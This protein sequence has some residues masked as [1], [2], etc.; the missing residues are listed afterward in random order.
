MVSM[1]VSTPHVVSKDPDVLKEITRSGVSL[2]L[3]QRPVQTEIAREIASLEAPHLPDKRHK[4]TL[5]SLDG[6]VCEL[7][8]QRGLDPQAFRHL[9]ADM[10][11]LAYQL[12]Q[13]SGS[14]RFIFR[15][16]TI[17]GNECHRFHLDR[18]PLRLICTYQG[19]GTEWLTDGQ[20][21]RAALARSA[22]NEAIILGGE[23]SQ[24][25]HFWV[26]IMRGDPQNQGHGLVHRSP[27]L[28]GT[29]QLRVLF[30]LDPEAALPPGSSNSK[31][32]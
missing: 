20:V 13:A 9:R 25:E 28:E 18:T 15:L 16:V 3:W 29:G 11:M 21:N 7:L 2:A 23:P 17:A 32:R 1:T 27:T 6:N 5:A 4:A 30:C 26:G 31:S 14:R 8:L 22:A 12:W 10:K 19:P 24:F